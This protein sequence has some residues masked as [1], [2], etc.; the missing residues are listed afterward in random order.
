[1]YRVLQILL[2]MDVFSPPQDLQCVRLSL[3]LHL[4]QI[5]LTMDVSELTRQ[6]PME[7]DAEPAPAGDAAQDEQQWLAE[8]Y[9]LVRSAAGV[10]VADVSPPL[11]RQYVAGAVTPFLRCCALYFH[12]LTGVRA[13]DELL[14][15]LP[16]SAQYPH[17]L[18]YLGLDS[19]CVSQATDCQSVLQDLIA[20]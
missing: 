4:V 15:P 13:P 14:Q 17:L 9:T 3:L 5:L 7:T 1:M 19:L 8:L 20:K 18:R 2:T 12:F 6:Q 16:L 11:L 10:E